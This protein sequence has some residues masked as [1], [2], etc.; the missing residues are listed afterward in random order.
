MYSERC[1]CLRRRYVHLFER[2]PPWKMPSW[3]WI[4]WLP[5]LGGNIH[6]VPNLPLHQFGSSTR[7]I[8]SACFVRESLCLR[9][10]RCI[11]DRCFF[12][13]P[14]F[15]ELLRRLFMDFSCKGFSRA[16]NPDASLNDT[17]QTLLFFAVGRRTGFILR[18]NA[19]IKATTVIGSHISQ[20]S[21]LSASCCSLLCSLSR[22]P[23]MVCHFFHTIKS[24]WKRNFCN[25]PYF[26]SHEPCSE[27]WLVS[28]FQLISNYWDIQH[29]WHWL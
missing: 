15:M 10:K 4:G 29:L 23:S 17:T 9:N 14:A 19:S 18:R 5:Q 25:G 16:G 28:I 20:W 11:L 3:E 13:K 1:E 8:W 22:Y 6:M 12:F 2:C 27:G 7:C 26:P 21:G 24:Q